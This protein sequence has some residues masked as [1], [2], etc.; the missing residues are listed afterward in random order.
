MQALRDKNRVLRKA[1]EANGQ[2]VVRMMNTD[3]VRQLDRWKAMLAEMRANIEVVES[4]GTAGTAGWRT[5]WNFQ[6]AKALEFQ[7]KLGLESCHETLPA[8][9][10]KLVF[11]DKKLCFDPPFE[12]VRKHYY[13]EL[14]TFIMLPSKFTGVA[15]E[16]GDAKE[17]FKKIVDRNSKAL[18]VVFSQAQL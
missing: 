1:H 4:E 18:V 12:E 3:L 2:L 10:V 8:M 11:K 15:G 6:L 13:K 5:H 9:G 14:K 7:Y 16:G 17:L